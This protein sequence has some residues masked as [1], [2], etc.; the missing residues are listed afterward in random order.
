MNSKATKIGGSKL[1]QQLQH[2]NSLGGGGGGKQYS[3]EVV[4]AS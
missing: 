3:Y 4:S 1:E 2:V